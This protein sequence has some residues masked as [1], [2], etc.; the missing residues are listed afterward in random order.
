ME[1]TMTPISM[2]AMRGSTAT[3]VPPLS[4]APTMAERVAR[5]WILRGADGCGFDDN[6]GPEAARSLA[7]PANASTSH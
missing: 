5:A 1:Q 6:I 4:H 2:K 7:T 3:Q